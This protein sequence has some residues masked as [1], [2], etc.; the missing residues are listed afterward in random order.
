MWWISL[1]LQVFGGIAAA[2]TIISFIAPQVRQKL[3]E[4]LAMLDGIRF[5]APWK[6][7]KIRSEVANAKT[8]ISILQTWIP[9]INTDLD[10]WKQ[11][12]SSVKRF[13]VLIAHNSLVDSRISCRTCN[14]QTDSNIEA[15]ELYNG[16]LSNGHVHIE[17]QQYT[18]LPFGPIY[19]ID[20][21]VYWGIY[22]SQ[23]DSLAG[24]QFKCH[25][26]SKIGKLICQSYESIW[27]RA[28]NAPNPVEYK[29]HCDK[30]NAY[31]RYRDDPAKRHTV[32][33]YCPNSTCGCFEKTVQSEIPV[34]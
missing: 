6:Q 13:R 26:D 19:I 5:A 21:T 31:L 3:F 24:P 9:T 15:I 11:L 28:G 29:R 1:T 33:S 32:Q 34:S 17:F 7:D 23:C 12:N 14:P 25:R 27:E 20:D 4:S 16:N 8:E 18:S 30:C 2:L 22:I 10:Q